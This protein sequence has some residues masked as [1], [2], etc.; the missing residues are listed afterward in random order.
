MSRED[1][2]VAQ[3]MAILRSRR[4]PESMREAGRKGGASGVGRPKSKEHKAKMAAGQAA[5]RER[6]AAEKRTDSTL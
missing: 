6:E 3:A 5:R 1:E 2:I 4:N